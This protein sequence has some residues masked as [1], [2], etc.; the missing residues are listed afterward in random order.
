MEVTWAATIPIPGAEESEGE[1]AVKA[2]RTLAIKDPED[3]DEEEEEI[4]GEE[5]TAKTK[6]TSSDN[7]SAIDAISKDR[8]EK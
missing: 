2:I 1:P 7:F 3:D 4:E 6:V 8:Q 5:E